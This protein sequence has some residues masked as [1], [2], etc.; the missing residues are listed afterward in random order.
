MIAG[1]DG[2]SEEMIS[3]PVL[4]PAAVG[5]KVT[6]IVQPTPVVIGSAVQVLDGKLKSPVTWISERL[7]GFTPT[8]VRFTGSVA[9]V[10]VMPCFPK[11]SEVGETEAA[12]DTTPVPL[13]GTINGLFG[14]LLVIVSD[15]DLA[16][17]TVGVKV[18]FIVQVAAVGMGKAVHVLEA[19]AKS[20]DVVMLEIVSAFAPML[21]RITL[22][23][24][25]VTFTLW[26]PKASEVGETEA[27]TGIVNRSL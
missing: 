9:L 13:N 10:V 7:R 22:L 12:D 18:T 3:E 20:P 23:G 8:L 15:P 27:P 26:F 21:V 19:K 2:S 16:P 11:L 17:A 5:V 14:S 4:V 6:F 24:A 25:L 1:L